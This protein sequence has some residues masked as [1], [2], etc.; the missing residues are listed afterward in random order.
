MATIMIFSSK[1]D[2]NVW[3][4]TLA[5]GVAWI[6]ATV[7]LLLSSRLSRILGPRGLVACERLMGMILTVIAVQMSLD[8]ISLFMKIG[9]LE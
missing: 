5:L 6:L 9:K 7:I 4:W 3:Q 2:S 1:Q 8:G